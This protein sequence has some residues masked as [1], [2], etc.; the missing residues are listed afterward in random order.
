MLIISGH[1]LYSKQKLFPDN[2][3]K[4]KFESQLQG[5]MLYK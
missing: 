5:V 4:D 2:I 1:L 3:I